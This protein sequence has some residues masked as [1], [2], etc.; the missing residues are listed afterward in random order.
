MANLLSKIDKERLTTGFIYPVFILCSAFGLSTWVLGGHSS[1]SQWTDLAHVTTGVI[2]S[3]YSPYY[4]YLHINRTLGLRRPAT[5]FSG[6]LTLFLL[7]G[8]IV[9]GWH[10]FLFGLSEKLAWVLAFHIASALGFIFIVGLHLVLHLVL[11]PAKRAEKNTTK[12]PSIPGHGSSRFYFLR[13]IS[14]TVLMAFAG[15]GIVTAV[16]ELRTAPFSNE[17]Q[18]QNY[19][20]PLSLIHISEPTRPY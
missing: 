12:F 17:P 2:L 10:I 7:L 14:V 9:S 5:L 19:T 20:Y 13:K 15:I 8:F 4:L 6:L 1:W 16:Y 18:T 3:I 11:F